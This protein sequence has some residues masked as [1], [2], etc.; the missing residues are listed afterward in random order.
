MPA[1]LIADVDVTEPEG[2]AEYSLAIDA[3]LAPYGARFLVRG[4]QVDV[5]EGDWSP[6]RIIV[7]EFASAAQLGAWYR[8]AEYEPLIRL[9]LRTATARLIAAEGVEASDG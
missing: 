9:R 3:T 6:T 5:L 8:S 7:I 2:Y 1:Y 4:G